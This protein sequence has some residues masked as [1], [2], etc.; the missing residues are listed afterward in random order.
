MLECR[1]FL[2]STIA[3]PTSCVQS[4]G[5]WAAQSDARGRTT[6]TSPASIATGQI[7]WICCGY[8]A[9]YRAAIA[10]AFGA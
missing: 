4:S 5:T 1:T 3:A 6:P 8:S 10:T 2:A 9:R 7:G